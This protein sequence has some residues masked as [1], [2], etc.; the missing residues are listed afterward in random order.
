VTFDRRAI[1]PSAEESIWNAADGWE[2]RRIDFPGKGDVARGA[3]LFVP[4]RGDHYEKYL[5]SL[6]EWT[7]RGWHVTAIDWRGQSGSGRLSDDGVTGHVDDFSIWI[8]DLAYFWERW[9][10]E[11]PG[12]HVLAA[13]SMGGHVVMRALGEHALQPEP[14]AVVMTAPMLGFTARFLPMAWMH[15]LAKLMCRLGNPKRPAWKW[16]EKPGEVPANRENLLTHD[17]DRYADELWWR[18]HRLELAMGPGSWRWVERAYAS[19]RILNRPGFMES[20]SMPVLLLGASNDKLV[21]YHSTERAAQR[22]PHGELVVFGRESR[23]E[24][25]REVDA[26]R[27]RAMAEI[28][29][30]LD[31]VAPAP[32]VQGQTGASQ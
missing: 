18:N 24:I 27:D 13:H 2:L 15:G 29:S 8:V 30:F 4:G 26:V 6:W 25:L 16:S 32:Q 1:P 22:L 10:E 17:D 14:D 21:D 28:D 7:L 11:R 9:V 12:P 23:H 19:T 3:I 5:E 20:V 31:R